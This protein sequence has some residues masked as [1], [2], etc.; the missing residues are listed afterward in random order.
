MLTATTRGFLQ[1]GFRIVGMAVTPAILVTSAIFTLMH[2]PVLP[3]ESVVAAMS[4]LFLLSIT[5]GAIRERTG[6]VA[7]C[8]IA[9]GLFNAFNLGLAVAFT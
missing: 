2:Y 3:P 6:R 7:P 9:H 1:Q 5:L 4:A 8:M